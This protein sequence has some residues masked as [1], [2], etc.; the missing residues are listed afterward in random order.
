MKKYHVQLDEKQRKQLESLISGGKG[1]ARSQTHAR[2]LLQTD[3]GGKA[4][5][6]D[7]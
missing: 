3:Q 6:L 7:R 2:I 4:T 1:S 5:G